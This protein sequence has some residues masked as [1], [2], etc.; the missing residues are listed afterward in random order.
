MNKILR[1][2]G[3]GY[4]ARPVAVKITA[5]SKTIFAGTIPTLNQRLPNPAEK[6]ASSIIC[7][8]EVPLDFEGS[9]SMTVSVVNGIMIHRQI[10]ANHLK[11]ESMIDGQL[12]L[13]SAGP[14]YYTPHIFWQDHN[15]LSCPYQHVRI[16]GIDIGTGTDVMPPWII[17]SDSVLS[18]DLNISTVKIKDKT[19]S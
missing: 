11:R 18:Y 19:A 14:N 7:S 3:Q 10:T 2:I 9:V 5:D 15:R 13:I 4:G 8:F 12:G 6:P 1:I 17:N 16:N